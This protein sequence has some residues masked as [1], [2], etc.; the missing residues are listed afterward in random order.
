[1]N[2]VII[3]SG[4]AAISAVESIRDID[5]ESRVTVISLSKEI[6]S[7]CL[8]PY[9][10]TGGINEEQVLFRDAFFYESMGVDPIFKKATKVIPTQSSVLLDDGSEVKYDKLLIATGSSPLSPRI[11]GI[12][13]E[14]V[15]FFNALEDARKIANWS[16]GTRRAV[17]IGAGFIGV[18]AAIS[19][20][21]KGM[22]VSLIEIQDRILPEMLDKEAALVAKEQLERNGIDVI[23]EAQVLEL[24]G[25]GR[26]DGV[27]L[28]QRRLDCEMVVVTAGVSPNIE[29]VKETEINLGTGIIVDEYMRTS[30]ENIYAAGDVAETI[31]IVTKERRINAIWPNAVKQGRVAARNILGIKSK[32]EGSHRMNVID[33]FGMPII[34]IGH[35]LPG[36]EEL[37]AY[38]KRIALKDDRVVQLTFMGNIRNVGVIQSLIRKGEDI[39][40]IKD[41]ILKDEFGYGKVVKYESARALKSGF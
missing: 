40:K 25:N 27:I 7:P 9:Y 17:V 32:Y 37:N 3:G 12:A 11:E 35:K 33:I 36:S 21:K 24:S 28:A 38:N 8:L 10:L 1:M 20:R 15:F 31:D 34:S 4:A 2:I 6:Y 41:F 39:S 14:G 18:E 16:K 26:V 22:E 23:L 5:R 13:K 29:L 30:M 19:L